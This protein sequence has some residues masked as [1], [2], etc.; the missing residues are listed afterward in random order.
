M[1]PKSRIAIEDAESALPDSG[2]N[3]DGAMGGGKVGGGGDGGGGA[4][5]I[6]VR[7]PTCFEIDG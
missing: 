6:E 2:S 4:T 7:T 1:P 5:T 3:G